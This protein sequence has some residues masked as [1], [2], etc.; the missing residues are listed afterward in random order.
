MI[1]KKNNIDQ[2]LLFIYLKNLIALVIFI[3]FKKINGSRK[4]E[5]A[6]NILFINTGQIG[7]LVLSTLVLVNEDLFEQGKEIYLL[8]KK[9]YSDLF[10]YYNG[11]VKIIYWDH[12]LYRFSFLY[13]I[14]FI[15]ELQK[16]NLEYAINFTTARGP[17][18]DEITLLSGATKKLCFANDQKHL[19]RI[20]TKH[21]DKYYDKIFVL[22]G[23]TEF[24]KQSIVLESIL[25]RKINLKTK[26]YLNNDIIPEVNSKLKTFYNVH[27]E[28]II[29]INPLS[30][31]EE[32]NWPGKYYHEL[33]HQFSNDNYLI[34][35]QGSKQQKN[36]ID[37][38]IPKSKNII[39]V[40]GEYTLSQSAALISIADLFI[41]ND[42]GYTHIAKA[43]NKTT[44]AIIGCGSYGSFFPYLERDNEYLLYNDVDC[45]GC[46]WRCIHNQRI[47]I[48][49]VTTRQV[50][51]LAK[52]ILAQQHEQQNN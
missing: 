2:P 6:Q 26:Y 32:K 42:S 52:K 30:D 22:R 5:K 16:L 45:K 44:I 9:K 46:E 23:K 3:L 21:Y 11:R 38:L 28:K 19:N 29:V 10:T 18:N 33:N 24:E 37:K 14:K 49:E 1:F 17:L 36:R 43:L 41:G 50:Y 15:K 8:V 25:T 34:V 48:E 31:I 47:C 40:A 35:Y 51:E 4:F 20:F 13:R 39:N 12:T 7:D 27:Y